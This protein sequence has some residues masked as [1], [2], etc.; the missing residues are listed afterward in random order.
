MTQLEMRNSLLL[1][2]S[3][4]GQQEH[5]PHLIIP[6]FTDNHLLIDIVSIRCVL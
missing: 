6:W 3:L 2:Q 4:N 5:F 1:P